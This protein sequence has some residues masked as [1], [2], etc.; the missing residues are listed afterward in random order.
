MI[1]L[2]FIVRKILISP[3]LKS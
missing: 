2:D 3:R 1:I